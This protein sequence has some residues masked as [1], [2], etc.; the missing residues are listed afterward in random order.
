[1]IRFVLLCLLLVFAAEPAA[2]MPAI[3]VAVSAAFASVG[4]SITAAA[5]NAFLIRTAISVGLSLLAQKLN[6]PKAPAAS[7]VKIDGTTAGEDVAMRF[8]VG[9]RMVGGHLEYHNSHGNVDKTPNAFYTMVISLSDVS[10]V[11]LRRLR[12]ND[13]FMTLGDTPHGDFGFPMLQ[14]RDG[15]TDYGW[16]KFYDGTQTT[17][18]GM[19]VNRYGNDPDQPWTPDHVLSGVAYAIVTMRYNRD[20]WQGP[21]M[22]R[23]E[24]DGIPLYDPRA[25]SS[26]GGS[27]PQRWGQVNTY[28]PTENAAVIAYNLM[29]G[30]PMPGGNIYGGEVA[31]A[32][33]PLAN[34]VAGMN[35]CDTPI[36][37][38]P[39]FQGGLEISADEEPAAYIEEL[40][41]AGL[42]Q[43]SELG[44]AF[45]TRWGA[46]DQAVMAITDDD[47]SV[48]NPQ[49]F[50]PFPGIEATYNAIRITHP[51]VET[52]WEPAQT[53]ALYNAAWEAEDGNRRLPIQMNVAACFSHA[54][55]QQ[56]A[57]AYIADE[58]RFRQHQ[59]VLP[60]EAQI[61][62]PLDTI[63]WTS[64]RNGYSNKLF[65]VVATRYMPKTMMVALTLRERDPSDYD[66]N[67]ELELP[68]APGLTPTERGPRSV[69]DDAWSLT[70]SSVPDSNGIARRPALLIE[71]DVETIEDA[72]QLEY[73]VELS[74]SLAPV[75]SGIAN[76]NSGL[77]YVFDGILAAETYRA[78][79]RPVLSAP[80]VWSDWKTA[81]TPDVRFTR[82]D[83]AEQLRQEFDAARELIDGTV[84]N[85]GG[86]VGDLRESVELALGVDLREPGMMSPTV[87]I[88]RLADLESIVEGWQLQLA[89]AELLRGS[90]EDRV[91]DAGV[92]IDPDTAEVRI[93]GVQDLENVVSLA[94]VR[95]DGL[96]AQIDILAQVATFDDEGLLEQFN[97]V[98][99]L[100]DAIN[101]EIAL[102]ATTLQFDDLSI[103]QDQSEAI[104]NAQGIS[105]ATIEA[106]VSEVDARLT[107]AETSISAIDGVA[108]ITSTVE[109][110][111]ELAAEDPDAAT[112]NIANNA[113]NDLLN[114]DVQRTER[115]A[116]RQT[117]SAWVNESNVAQAQARLLLEAE[118]GDAR[119]TIQ[120]ESLARASADSALAGQINNLSATVGDNSADINELAVTR[121]TAAGAV[122]AVNQTISAE[123]NNVQALAEATAFAESTAGGITEGFI[124][125]TGSGGRLELVSVAS[126]TSGPTT[127]ARISGDYIL[128]DGNTQVAG[129]FLV[130]G[131]NI[132]LDGDTTVTGAFRVTNANIG[133]DIFSDNYSPGNSGWRIR[134]N[135]AAEFNGV[136]MSRQLQVATGTVAINQS[137]LHSTEYAIRFT[138]IINTGF[139]VQPWTGANRTYQATVGI[140]DASV[141]AP[142]GAP[143][144][145]DWGWSTEVIS[146]TNWNGAAQ[147][148]LRVRFYGLNVNSIS[149]TLRWRLYE[150]T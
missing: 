105:L 88:P 74:G 15:S 13:E 34:A 84:E 41:K 56:L 16:I 123:Y 121:V 111:R 27:G 85:I 120:T 91:R 92:Y 8:V 73:Q 108:E 19:L 130:S 10:G 94:Q 93:R 83:M 52:A 141:N 66:W 77:V 67:G 43:V 38:R 20:I 65:E 50:D 78:R 119:A 81:T 144:N 59:I 46:P 3:G 124:W 79:V 33:L 131:Q 11:A 112:F 57:A 9:R 51:N 100:F 98:Q 110:V 109:A 6:K 60:P 23:F 2:A 125:R 26:V 7:G 72:R 82:L 14:K 48:S 62:E 18:D 89:N 68:S 42:G 22:L 134:Q 99:A 107:S 49:E 53:P 24:L 40:L 47:I 63:A 39:Q 80:A 142:S 55:A 126:G 97:E 71:W 137:G 1:M 25:D 138:T 146:N 96:E 148:R 90:L 17:A 12:V 104:I 4:V 116:A 36:A 87:S 75:R 135:G 69:A 95:V 136:V 115:S 103:R 64:Q 30:I 28:Q 150:V 21:P 149:G 76:G 140:S 127:I 101:A 118:I 61:L 129:D 145:V 117:I 29:R 31:A 147:I 44:G 37:G 32:D 54:Q 133:G 132:V 113:L 45:R 114:R 106:E 139:N 122:A 58:R 86:V 128:L 102:R 70:G 143:P 5:V 35:V